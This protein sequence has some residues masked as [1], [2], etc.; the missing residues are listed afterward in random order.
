MAKTPKK[1][2]A[3]RVLKELQ[4]IEKLVV[5]LRKQ[6]QKAILAEKISPGPVPPVKGGECPP[7]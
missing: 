2:P 3:K 4:H 6:V 1:F 5:S 7:P